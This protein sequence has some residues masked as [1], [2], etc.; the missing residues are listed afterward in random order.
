MTNC[1]KVRLLANLSPVIIFDKSGFREVCINA[2][3]IPNREKD[4]NITT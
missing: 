1:P 4:A 2:F 3:P